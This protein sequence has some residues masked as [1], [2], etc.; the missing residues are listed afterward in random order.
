MST[1]GF[2]FK[3]ISKDWPFQD[4]HER[5]CPQVGFAKLSKKG[6]PSRTS[7]RMLLVDQKCASKGLRPKISTKGF[8]LIFFA[9]ARERLRLRIVFCVFLKGARKA[10]PSIVFIRANAFV[11]KL[12]LLGCPRK[13]LPSR[14]SNRRRLVHLT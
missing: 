9:H 12:A 13:A 5:L 10:L 2:A 1:K 14:I 11:D 7:K 4:I 6:M 3:C 8:A